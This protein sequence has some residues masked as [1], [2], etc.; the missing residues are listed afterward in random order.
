MIE[1]RLLV[2][3]MRHHVVEWPGSG[4]TLMLLHG[5]LDHARIFDP[6]AAELAGFRLLAPDLRGHGDTDWVPAGGYYYFPDYAADVHAIAHA[7]ATP[8]LALVGHSMGG[9]VASALA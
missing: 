1:H 3:G 4:P 8:P 5:Y 6:L 2:R 9:G 7:L